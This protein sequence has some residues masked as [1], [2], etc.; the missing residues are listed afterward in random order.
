[1][2][3]FMKVLVAL[4]VVSAVPSEGAGVNQQQTSTANPIR[5]VVT[6][7]QMMQKK[8]SEEGEKETE[9][10]EKFMCYC[11]N[12]VETLKA[13]IAEAEAKA[14]E[15][16]ADIEEAEAQ[17]KQLKADIAKAKEDRE[18]AKEAMAEATALREKEAAAFAAETAEDKANIAAIK[19]AWTAISNGM[20]GSFLQT[21]NAQVLKKLVLN[22]DAMTDSVRDEVTAFLAGSS[23][24]GYAPAS[25]EI[26]GILKQMGDTMAK[27]LA[28]AEAAE[29]EAI[30]A[31]EELMAAKTK[32]VEAL[33][34]EIEEKMV[35]LGELQVSIVEMKEDLDDTVK[36]SLEDKKFLADLEKGCATKT[37]EHEENMKLRAEEITT[38]EKALELLSG[39]A[40]AALLLAMPR[41]HG[42][43]AMLMPPPRN[44]IDSTIPGFDWGNGST[45]TGHLEPLQATCANG[46]EACHPGQSVFWFSQGCTP[47]CESCDG[48]G[49]RRR[50]QE[51]GGH[52]PQVVLA[53]D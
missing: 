21:E 31:Y 29:A 43:G 17:V 20:A 39:A 52:A 26:V 12:G 40:V 9:L 24:E 8:I 3:S 18:A 22:S 47:G 11:K 33:T 49:Q 7:L 53:A 48:Q 4:L 1:M 28:E 46:T 50:D 25:G 16:L 37:A 6:M 13:S 27:G 34:K 36:A 19:K 42:H 41:V 23:S 35:R 44:A 38:I 30:K 51:A 10:F 45:R 14:P 2:S 5:K 32:E 15:L